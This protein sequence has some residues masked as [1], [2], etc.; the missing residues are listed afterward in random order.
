LNFLDTKYIRNRNG[1]H[2]AFS[3]ANR[4]KEKHIKVRN[5]STNLL[6]FTK[7]IKKIK[8]SKVKRVNRRSPRAGIQ[9]TDH[10]LSG[11]TIKNNVPS[12]A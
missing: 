12:R 4:A 7:L 6:V 9:T 8:A 11:L 5:R 3:L 1:I 10:T 2:T